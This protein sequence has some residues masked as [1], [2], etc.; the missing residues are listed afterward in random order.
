[1]AVVGECRKAVTVSEK[2]LL[3]VSSVVAL[4]DGSCQVWHVMFLRSCEGGWSQW[5]LALSQSNWFCWLVG[6]LSPACA[7]DWQV[8]FTEASCALSN[9]REKS[10]FLC[11]DSGAFYRTFSVA[12]SLNPVLRI[13]YSFQF[14]SLFHAW[15]LLGE[16]TAELPGLWLKAGL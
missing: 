9:S 6:L 8:L 3:P 15:S 1:M 13:P 12:V 16:F 4:C 11:P 14:Y 10:A 5:D 2:L 7:G